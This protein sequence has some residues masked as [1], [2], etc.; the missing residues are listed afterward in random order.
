MNVK[1]G[2]KGSKG[3][4]GAK[5]DAGTSVTVTNVQESTEDGGANVVTFSDGTTLNVKNGSKGSKGDTGASQG[6]GESTDLFVIHLLA[7]GTMDK[8]FTDVRNAIASHKSPI[9]IDNTDEHAVYTL[10]QVEYT[11]NVPSRYHF[12]RFRDTSNGIVKDVIKYTNII[13]ASKSTGAVVDAPN[14]K[15]IKFTGAVSAEYDGSAAVTVNIPEGGSGGGGTSKYQQPDWGVD[16][17]TLTEILPEAT[18]TATAETEYMAIIMEKVLVTAGTVVTVTYNGTAYNCTAYAGDTDE[19]G[20]VIFVVLGNKAA[21]GGED[22]GEPF[23]AIFATSEEMVAEYGFYGAIVPLDGSETF[24]LSIAAPTIH[25][26]PVEYLGGI[27]TTPLIVNLTVDGTN[28]NLSATYDEIL[29]A[30]NSNRNVF[31]YNGRMLI[32][33]HYVD[34]GN[35][36]ISFQAIENDTGEL[37]LYIYTIDE[38]NVITYNSGTRLMTSADRNAL[39]NRITA[40]EKQLGLAT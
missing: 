2:S 16:T 34:K 7:D 38:T 13:G 12:S 4:T 31:L 26:I 15:S 32:P 10:S 8:T 27:V 21:E 9:V 17:A 19:Y 25:T 23:F 28:V 36:V 3:D 22:T 33:L 5:G 6:G 29:A 35:G 39:N 20:N 14:P 37:K 1:N 40:I 11:S 24:T 30:L 18:Y